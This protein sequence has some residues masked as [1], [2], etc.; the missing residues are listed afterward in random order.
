MTSELE[1]RARTLFWQHQVP[2]TVLPAT[3]AEGITV[4]SDFGQRI[5]FPDLQAI[6]FFLLGY[7]TGQ[8]S[9]PLPPPDAG[10]EGEEPGGFGMPLEEI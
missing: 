10:A 7:R 5:H 2:M 3:G 1:Q 4:I 8:E 6:Q 9:S